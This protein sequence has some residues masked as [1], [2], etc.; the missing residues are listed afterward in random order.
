[1]IRQPS[2]FPADNSIPAVSLPDVH[3]S[4]CPEPRVILRWNLAA[5]GIWHLGARCFECGRFIRYLK[6]DP[7]ILRLA[8]E[9]P[10][11]P[12]SIDPPTPALSG[13]SPGVH[14]IPVTAELIESGKSF[15]G[16]WNKIQL[17]IL[18]VPWPPS[19]GWKPLAMKRRITPLEAQR[20]VSLRRKGFTH[21]TNGPPSRPA[22]DTA[23]P[24]PLTEND[25]FIIHIHG[26]SRGNPG[27]A[28]IGYIIERPGEPEVKHAEH[29]G[30]ATNNVAEYAA[31]LHALQHAQRLGGRRLDIKS[32]SNLL[33][34]QMSG[35]YKVRDQGLS[36]LHAQA[37]SLC[38]AFD[39]VTF[40]HIPREK[41]HRADALC[42]KALDEQ[43]TPEPA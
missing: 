23:G 33:V 14:L 43:H 5:N 30:V 3:C 21:E 40:S 18:G 24:Y 26:A 31:L 12:P 38:R 11:S 36:P 8:S 42:N 6:Q 1:M 22:A 16:G 28:A 34:Q 10:V 41:H 35:T 32:D 15:R 39:S 20:F 9:K 4:S 19:S 17:A 37:S 2:L 7:E 29:I 13:D 25:V 27:P